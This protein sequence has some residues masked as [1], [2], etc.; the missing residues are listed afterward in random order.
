[1]SVSSIG[2][3]LLAAGASTR[4]GEPKQLLKFEGETLLHRAVR[5][6][7][8]TQHRPVVVVLGA[9]SDVLQDEIDSTDARVVVN[10]SWREGMGS[11]I[12]CGLQTLEAAT[13]DE[14]EAVIVLLCD[15][16]YITGEALNRLV[17]AYSAG[18]TPLVV[19]AYEARGEKTL[20]VPALFGRALFLELMSLE[21]ASGAKSV[22]AR[23]AS[24]AVSVAMPEAAFD[25]DTPD[26]YR[27]L[28]NHP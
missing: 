7:L 20:G 16:P 11:S 21:G 2:I 25:V 23:Y 15:Q 1:M 22:V 10:Q 24:K 5:V 14:I 17:G 12:R 19:S 6:A 3:I 28:H 9:Q 13:H 26:D 4:M 8:E 18:R 27:A